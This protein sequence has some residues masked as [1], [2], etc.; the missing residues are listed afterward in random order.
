MVSLVFWFGALVAAVSGTLSGSVS[1]V[2]PID[3]L[4][5]SEMTVKLVVN[6]DDGDSARIVASTRI[7]V[8]M[9]PAVFDLTFDDDM[10]DKNDHATVEVEI[11]SDGGLLFANFAAVP[12]DIDVAEEP[13]EITVFLLLNDLLSGRWQVTELS[14]TP[15]NMSWRPHIAFTGAGTFEVTAGCNTLSGVAQTKQN[16]LRPNEVLFPVETAG[17]LLACQAHLA[18]LERAFLNDLQDVRHYQQEGLD[19]TL[20][21]KAETAIMRLRFIRS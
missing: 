11:A 6:A 13:V 21:D 15:L 8:A 9:L 16:L 20:F 5:P 4:K 10:I 3:L 1:N 12:V 19:L 7:P 17:T 2:D 18:T 14:G